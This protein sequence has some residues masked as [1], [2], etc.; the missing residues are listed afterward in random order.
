MSEI[1]V[2]VMGESVVTASVV[3]WL[4]KVGEP[5]SL[6][7]VLV[8][9]ETDKVN[10]EV[11][12]ESAGVL[13]EIIAP[14]GTDVAVGGL[15]GRLGVAGVS[16]QPNGVAQPNVPPPTNEKASP[17]AL[18]ATPVARRVAEV[19]GVDL[20][21]VTGSGAGGKITRQDVLQAKA[22]N[23]S[24]ASTPTPVTPPAPVA[25]ASTPIPPAD[26]PSH[27]VEIRER[28]S[29]RRRTI[30][31]RLVEAQHTAAMLTTFN[32]VDMS[33]VMEIRKRHQ[34]HFST[35]EG[36]KLGFMSFFVRAVTHAL[37][38]FPRL[39]AEIQADEIVLKQ[40]YDIGIAVGAEEGLVVPV[41]RDAD[42]L[43]FGQIERAIKELGAKAK[44]NTLSIADL[45]GGTFTITNGGIFGSMLSTPILNGPQ[46]GILGMHNI[47]ERPM[48][49]NGQIVIRPIMYVALSY[50]HRIVDGREAVQFLVR[51]KQSIEDPVGMLL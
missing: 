15:L 30:A 41:L 38:E 26:A 25:P 18:S 5:V 43:S 11:A 14:P 16:A 35:K 44:N 42:K 36:I 47:V 27:R 40:Y 1:K 45:L 2:P 37:I 31:Q 12:A 48:V 4:K 39:N 49:V 7:D 10:V 46:V 6:G 24:S 13:T 20:S 19:E 17:V 21:A 9:L 33:A 50:D 51:V 29:R 34:E 8:S 22:P 3:E 28:M 23:A 32:E